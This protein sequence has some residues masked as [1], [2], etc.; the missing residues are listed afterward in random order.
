[1]QEVSV[2]LDIVK[3]YA[4]PELDAALMRVRLKLDYVQRNGELTNSVEKTPSKSDARG[5]RRLIS[6]SVGMI[7]TAVA[8]LFALPVLTE[9]VITGG[10]NGATVGTFDGGGSG[11]ANISDLSDTSATDRQYVA[12]YF[13]PNVTGSYTFGLS[14]SNE[15]TVLI[16]YSDTF[17]PD[18]P[19]INAV[20][21][22]DDVSAP[23]G[24]GG[25]V[26]EN[27]GAQISYCPRISA[28]L[29]SD[30]TYHIVIT[31]YLP[32]MTVSDGV[33]FYI[34]GEPITIGSDVEA[35]EEEEA[36][37]IAAPA[38]VTRVI[39]A[40]TKLMMAKISIFE[41]RF[42]RDARARHIRVQQLANKASKAEISGS[43]DGQA[44]DSRAAPNFNLSG[45]MYEYGHSFRGDISKTIK[46]T[47]DVVLGDG[48]NGARDD[49]G[50]EA[51]RS[52]RIVVFG[53]FVHTNDKG[54]SESKQ[55]NAKLAWEQKI[56]P[57]TTGGVF[58]GGMA[59][60]GDI[61]GAKPG[62]HDF[63][64][65]SLGAYAIHSP[66]ERFHIG[67]ST[68]VGVV[69]NKLKLRD[70]NDN[71]Q[72]KF[73]LNTA[74]FGLNATGL[75]KIFRT[76]KLR[77]LPNQYFNHP[78]FSKTHFIEEASDIELWPTLMLDY[79][80]SDFNHIQSTRLA[81]G[82]I[83][84]IVPKVA[85]NSKLTFRASPELKLNID[86]LNTTLPENKLTIAPSVICEWTDAERKTNEC[87]F[88][89][90]LNLADRY[91][92]NRLLK[93]ELQNVESRRDIS[94]SLNATIPF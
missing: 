93:F 47:P 10:V 75:V 78:A 14:K 22:N 92:V 48:W 68:S 73:D 18:T 77:L 50:D 71:L 62:D 26:M 8:G 32:N 53:D 51:R 57:R 56:G 12:Q 42:L 24:A 25:V 80:K 34:N 89:L 21:L 9:I 13:K 63:T 16:L 91:E 70:G 2:T 38:K 61:K 40:Q 5:Y 59:G 49:S 69:Q 58:L 35:A 37:V 4:E 33:K 43:T 82:V 52:G 20:S 64:A 74:T 54:K 55:I 85:D 44:A 6:L 17:N 87:G 28:N 76:K 84:E 19:S 66:S 39:K 65:T 83:N 94:A 67:V 41:T 81:G 15:D 88:G 7:F 46:V 11:L 29:S 90:L 60:D 79:S 30:N 27:C 72:S 36:K 31:S 3:N 86:S 23:F 1:M 45:Q